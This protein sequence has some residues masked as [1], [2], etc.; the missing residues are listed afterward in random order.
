MN[1]GAEMELKK[2]EEGICFEGVKDLDL[3]ETFE[4]GQCFRWQED[5]DG[6]Y[7]GVVSGRAVRTFI[8]NGSLYIKG[9]RPEDE[10]F[11]KNYFDFDTDYSEIK[12]E[13]SKDDDTLKKAIE[14]GS[15][16]R[17]LNQ[18]PFET[19][20]TFIISANNRI[21]MIRRSVERISSYFGKPIEFEGKTYYSFPEPEI[22][23]KL[24]EED[25]QK[26]GCG[27]RS[28]YILET[29]QRIAQGEAVLEE[30][31][32]MP[33][34]EAHKEL[35]KL[36][37]I[38]TKVADCILLFSMKKNEAFPVDVWVKRV[39]Q[40]FYLAPD[41]SLKKIRDFGMERF[42]QNAGI[43]QEYLFN[44]ARINKINV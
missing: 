10:E 5:E 2:Y 15:G 40:Y 32:K 12:C 1:R 21:P 14:C 31:M 24:K 29:S 43:A 28:P 6:S 11:W 13:L 44:Y 41:V 36:K 27:F 7:V 8:K 18:E 35:I 3:K 42:G 17:I 25:L 9:G 38:G 16:I 34:T 20:I 39:M 26:C 30:I 4:C 22:L 37:G 23:S 19:T 33:I